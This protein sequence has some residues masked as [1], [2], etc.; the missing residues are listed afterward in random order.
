MAQESRFASSKKTPNQR[1]GELPTRLQSILT[2]KSELLSPKKRFNPV[3]PPARAP[4]L[5]LR[6]KSSELASS[7]RA[8]SEAVHELQ[9]SLSSTYLA[10][11]QERD[12]QSMFPKTKK[13]RPPAKV[14]FSLTQP[15]AKPKKETIEQAQKKEL[16]ENTWITDADSDQYTPLTLPF[17]E[18]EMNRSEEILDENRKVK[19]NQLIFVQ[20]PQALPIKSS[21]GN[22][23]GK[24]GKL[25]VFKSG[26]MVL[27]IGDQ[28]FE[29]MPGVQTS[30]YQEVGCQSDD[31]LKLLG[32]VNSQLIVAPKLF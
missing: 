22:L 4:K 15:E 30:F 31:K 6:R 28:L 32:P 10:G 1:E 24:I 13:S 2:P 9:Q 19:E 29:V 16:E 20:M 7:E 23:H 3:I 27:N 14:A 5:V 11:K 12:P 17:F 25:K 18:S 21:D 8:A 26:K